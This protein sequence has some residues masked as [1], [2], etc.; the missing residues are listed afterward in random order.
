MAL[1]T[2]GRVLVEALAA[3][4]VDTVFGIPG[5]H[6]LAIYAALAETGVRHVLLRHEQGVG[7]AADGYARVSGRPGVCVTTTGPGLLNAA[8]ALAQS[9]SDSVPVLVIAPGMPIGHPAAGNGEL[10]ETKNQSAALEA[11]VAHSHR[12]GSIAEIPVAVARA[13]AAMR[14]GRPRPV[15]IEIPL[16]LLEATGEAA[17]VAPLTAGPPVPPA[18]ELDRAA[19]LLRAAR[20]P[21]IVAGGGANRA[22]GALR[23]IAERL[24]A[25]V[26]TSMN[27]KGVLPDD[28]PLALGAG[29]AHAPVRDFLGSCDLLLA[30]GTELA[31]S[32]M[33]YGGVPADVPVV[34][35]DVDPVQLVTNARPAVA[36]LGDA[37]EALA[38]LLDRLGPPD[39]AAGPSGPSG[40]SHEDTGDIRGAGNAGAADD[41]AGARDGHTRAAHW[42]GLLR[43]DARERGGPWL[44]IVEAL[45]R[46]LGRD[47]V[48]AG[49]STMACYYGALGNLR[50]HTPAGYLYPTGFG[51][52]GYGLPAAVGAS[53]AAPERPVVVLEGDGGFMFTATELA[54]AAALG[55]PLPVVVVDNG[56]YGEIRRQM[57]ARGDTVQAVDLPPVDLAGLARSMGC[58]AHVMT[59]VSVPELTHLLGEALKADRPTVIVV[60]EERVEEAR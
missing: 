56:G 6:N 50:G 53:V 25:P 54:A 12:V 51:T 35:V 16:D 36:V 24:G 13:F 46:T 48:L 29:L 37:G 28:H 3:H 10:H 40:P 32:D 20:A 4:G 14:S 18:A 8:T 38:G 34:R 42:R 17:P 1:H 11:I 57:E 30:V 45:Q 60:P 43:A 58:H 55:L 5:T 52:L 19:G 2:G 47:G 15:Y 44:W 33:W 49:D 41:R 31:P 23:A 21:G 27:G 39:E 59:E 22:A 9:Y 7:F 26:V